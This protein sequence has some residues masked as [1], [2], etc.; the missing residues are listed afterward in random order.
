MQLKLKF[1]VNLFKVIRVMFIGATGGGGG[2]GP[3]KLADVIVG[4][5]VVMAVEAVDGIAD[6]VNEHWGCKLV[7]LLPG[8]MSSLLHFVRCPPTV[9]SLNRFRCS[10]K[11]LLTSYSLLWEV[12]NLRWIEGVNSRLP[13]PGLQVFS[14]LRLQL[15]HQFF[16][17]F[18]KCIL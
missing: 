5:I 15:L 9:S 11:A 18:R 17:K 8:S 4:I 6:D 12:G 3:E 16:E 1:A 13:E 2:V 10:K 7:I 14:T